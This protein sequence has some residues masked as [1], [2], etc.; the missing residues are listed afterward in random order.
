MI[1]TEP[2]TNFIPYTKPPR[3]RHAAVMFVDLDHFMRI[4]IDDPP[5]AVF[6]LL[7]DFQY[8]V[9]DQVSR[10]GGELNSYQGDGALATFW[11]ESDNADSATRTLQCARR[12]LEQV[13]VLGCDY[14]NDRIPAVSVSIGLQYGEIWT[15]TLTSSKSFGPTLIGDAV[16]VAARLEKQAQT[17]GTKIVAGDELIQRARC[18]SQTSDLTQFVSAGPVFVRGRHAPVHVWML[19]SQPTEFLQESA[20]VRSIDSDM[21]C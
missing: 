2:P 8:V 9:T 4:C 7:S 12:I 21:R 1:S 17:L 13:H 14:G 19:R 15:S 10:F 3:H 18:E 6:G 16:N 20:P 11:D 5:E